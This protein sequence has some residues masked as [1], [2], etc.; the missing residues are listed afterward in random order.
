[1]LAPM[2]KVSNITSAFSYKTPV[3]DP[4]SV[5]IRTK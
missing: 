2:L 1:M 5:L 4:V 3:C